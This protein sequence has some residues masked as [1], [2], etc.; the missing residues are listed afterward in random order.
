M[1][2]KS[3]QLFAIADLGSPMSFLNEKTARHL[4]QNNKEA[5]I[6]TIP[7]RDSARNLACYN[8][9]TIVPKGRLIIAIQSRGWKIQSAPLIVVDDKKA[10]I[11]G[12]NL[13]PQIGIKLIQEHQKHNEH[14]IRKQEEFDPAIKQWIKE[15]FAQ[16]CVR[17][18]KSKNHTMKTQFIKEFVP[19]QQKRRRFP[20]H[21]QERVEGELSKLIDQKHI[22]ELDK[23]SDRQFISPIFITV[24]KD[25]TGKLALDS[26][27]I[28]KFIHKNKYQMPNIDLLQDNIAQVV[29]S[30]KT[31]HTL[32]SKLDLRYAYSQIPL[33]QKTRE[34]CNFSLIS[35]NATGTY[36]FQTGFCGF[37]D[38][39]A[40]FQK[41][42][43]LTLTNCTNTY[44][45]L[46]DILIVTKGST[47]L[48]QQKLKAVLDK[49]DEENLA[50]AVEKCKF[51]C[52]QIEWLGFNINSEGTTPLIKK[53]EAIEKLSAPKT[54]KQPKSFMG[55]I[56]HLTRYIPNLAQATAALRPLLKKKQNRKNQLSG[57][58]NIT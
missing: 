9:E 57:P 56:H 46:D 41:A 48:H 1:K 36:R 43:D 42:F 55:S 37:T 18:G 40:K 5:M 8:G 53:T 58:R 34:Q 28:N 51:A 20:I 45:Y 3:E 47:E 29:K 44:A 49:L 19:I 15:N 7:T 23:R 27:K 16:L 11:I 21:L 4:Q 6:K 24:K 17:I 2:T 12:R 10:N 31:K 35:G 25:Q 33:D 50:I 32:F 22:I 26:K 14:A 30:D 39:P 38:M 13:L 52:K 54:F